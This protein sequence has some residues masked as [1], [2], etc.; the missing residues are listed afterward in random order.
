MPRWWEDA[1]GENYYIGVIFSPYGYNMG[2]ERHGTQHMLGD[3]CF[4]PPLNLE[5]KDWDDTW[6]GAGKSVAVS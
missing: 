3:M 4:F 5:V 2:W 6:V 1:F